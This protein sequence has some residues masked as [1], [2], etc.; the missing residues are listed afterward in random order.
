MATSGT[1]KICVVEARLTK[2]SGTFT[3]QDPY[4]MFENRYDRFKTKVAQDGG[5]E[6]QFNEDFEMDVKY[7]GDDFKMRIYAKNSIMSD[8]LLGEAEIKTSGL[9]MAGGI[10]DWWKVGIKGEDGGAIRF[11]CEF[12]PK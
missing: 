8:D 12:I 1:L 3:T 4:V 5:K 10:D 2:D 6:P 9:C 11:R 7:V